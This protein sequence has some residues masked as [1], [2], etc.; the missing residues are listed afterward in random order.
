MRRAAVVA[1]LLTLAGHALAD[2]AIGDP[3]EILLGNR[4]FDETRFAQFAAVH[5]APD[6][7]APLAVGD[8]VVDDTATTGTPLPGPFAGQAMNCRACHLDVE[9]KTTPGGGGRNYADFARRSPIPARD[10]GE[11]HTVRN[12]QQ[13]LNASLRRDG[14]FALHFDAEF[15]TLEDLV[16]ATFTGRNFGWYPDERATAVAWIARVVR[17]DDG[18]GALAQA[19]GGASYAGLFAGYDSLHPIDLP[20][21]TARRFDVR[22]ASDEQILAAVAA[23]VA[24][25]VR[26][27]VGAQDTA[28]AF[29]ASPYDVFLRKN[30]LP[31]APRRAESP[32]RY[33]RRLAR[34]VA[35]LDAPAF[36]DAADGRFLLH[37]HDF[38]FGPDELHG[39]RTFLSPK[40]G[41]CAAC[42][43]APAF[44]DFGVHN[45]GATQDEYDAVHGPG[46]FATIAIP[47]L[48]ARS[49][50][51]ARFLPPSAAHPRAPG[52]F[53]AIARPDRPGFTDL[54]LWNVFANPDVADTRRTRAL[55]RLVCASRGT[56]G[57]PRRPAALLPA[58]VALFKT[59]G[60]RDLG[61][62]APYLHDGSRD[63]LADVVR[64]YA[65]SA[66]LA[67]AGLLRNGARQLRKVRIADAEIAPVAA[68]LRAL[69]EDFE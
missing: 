42:H 37:P 61:H 67:R 58:T 9:H 28:G 62:S 29:A 50:D 47:D 52:P 54:G 32:A 39:L 43:P 22:R 2:P 19:F 4:L 5:G 63:T 57:C 51:P 14:A 38:V 27:L 69:D 21:P 34:L 41:N 53:R 65:R 35:R 30:G 45:T 11:T 55:A 10:D 31:V 36:V 26:S 20:I 66:D 44:T 6:P 48:A 3:P 18:R 8:P 59:P 12:S 56:R 15:A 23:F 17:E 33:T 1:L 13:L 49:A 64:F 25:Y 7:N 16:A 68:F 40:A 60:L 46:S 24:D